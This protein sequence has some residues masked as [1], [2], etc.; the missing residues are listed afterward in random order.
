MKNLKNVLY[1][2]VWDSVDGANSK[3]INWERYK[4][5][6]K[7]VDKRLYNIVRDKV[8]EQLFHPTIHKINDTKNENNENE[9]NENNG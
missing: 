3:Q 6:E 5:I 8:Q 4:E 1:D 7:I 9:N 2:Q